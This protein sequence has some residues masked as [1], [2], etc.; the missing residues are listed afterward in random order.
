MPKLNFDDNAL[1]RHPEIAALR[2]AEEEDPRERA[3]AEIG[4]SYVGLDG[5]IGCM[6]NGAGLAMATLDMI[7]HCGGSPANFLDAGGGV[8]VEDLLELGAGVPHAGQVGHREHRGL[9]RDPSGQAHRGA[10]AAAARA[11]GDRDEGR[12]VGFE[13]AHG[14]P[15]LGLS[16][17]VLGREE[18]ERE[19][20]PA[21]SDQVGERTSAADGHGADSM[22]RLR[23]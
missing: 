5:D 8:L 10:A 9:A 17:L 7:S 23:T 21:R 19:G 1:F 18:L 2:D 14:V 15:Q 4:L 11:V 6:V 12:V 22:E 3:A 16:G 13:R 20:A